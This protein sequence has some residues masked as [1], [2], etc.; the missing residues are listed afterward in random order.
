MASRCLNRYAYI[1]FEREHTN[2]AKLIF[3][4]SIPL[5]S[6]NVHPYVVIDK[7]WL[8]DQVVQ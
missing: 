2:V 3:L 6:D 1:S 4:Y 8:I 5:I 7:L